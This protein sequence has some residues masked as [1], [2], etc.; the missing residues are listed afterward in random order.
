MRFYLDEDLSPAIA[1]ILRD[2]G[3]DTRSAH[4][5]GMVG[6]TNR[7]QLDYAAGEGRVLVTRNARDFRVLAG[8]SI[9]EQRPHAG[10]VL[11]PPSVR[12]SERPRIAD[13]LE[14]LARDRPGGLGAYDLLYLPLSPPGAPPGSS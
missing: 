4:E 3:L 12:G 14:A 11:C 7:E 13:A 5:A 10:I 8:R 2:R 6:A 9:Q 1:R